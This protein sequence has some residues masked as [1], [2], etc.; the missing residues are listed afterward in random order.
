[1]ARSTE[2]IVRDLL[3]HQALDLAKLQAQVERLAE[4]NAKLQIQLAQ[5]AQGPAPP[6][7]AAQ[8][9]EPS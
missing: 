1:M 5:G 9:P 8:R 2:D 6:V 4:D 7:H 3:G